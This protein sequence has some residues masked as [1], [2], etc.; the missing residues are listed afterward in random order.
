M[1]SPERG[2]QAIP[3]L[4]RVWDLV[5]MSSD[6][7]PRSSRG[8]KQDGCSLELAIDAAASCLQLI[9]AH[10]TT[11][12]E[13]TLFS[14]GPREM[15]VAASLPL[16]PLTNENGQWINRPPE[17]GRGASGGQEG[18]ALPLG[19]GSPDGACLRISLIS[20][21]PHAVPKEI[22]TGVEWKR[23]RV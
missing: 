2:W 3:P 8:A 18:R 5:A 7:T 10:Y 13:D 16:A 19:G 21:V 4:P 12:M 6:A 20:W 15:A 1:V 17:W 9:T 22:P 11:G 23:K 14:T